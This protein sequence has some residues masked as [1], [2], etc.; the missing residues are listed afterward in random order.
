MQRCTGVNAV[1]NK[2][3]TGK[4][5][6]QDAN[7]ALGVLGTG[8]ESND[9][10]SI[11][12][13]IC[14]VIEATGGVVTPGTYNQLY[15]GI[16]VMI[17]D[18]VGGYALDTGSANTFVVTLTPAIAALQ[19]GMEVR[20]KTANGNPG[21]ASTLN[22]GTGAV[23]LVSD[24]GAALTANQIGTGQLV[25]AVYNQASNAWF[26]TNIMSATGSGTAGHFASWATAATLGD[27]GVIGSAAHMAATS[28][29]VTYVASV[30][31]ATVGH[32]AAFTDANGSI[33][34]S[35][36]VT[37]SIVTQTA[38]QQNAPIVP[39]AVGGT[40]DAITATYSPVP[41][42]L[43]NGMTF[44]VEAASAN[45]TTTPTFTPNSGTIAAATIVKGANQALVAGDIAGARHWVELQWDASLSKWVLLNPAFGVSVRQ[46]AAMGSKIATTSGTAIQFTRLPSGTKRV[47]LS[48]SGV[49][50]STSAALC[51]QLGTGSTPQA[52]GYTGES[53]YISSSGTAN[54]SLASSTSWV[55][56]TQS[57]AGP[58]WGQIT[59]TLVDTATNTWIISG[60][61]ACS[62]SVTFLNPVAYTVALTGAL[63]M[64]NMTTT[65]GSAAF[66]GGM[67]NIIYE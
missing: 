23:A 39:S 50:L 63:G 11:Q 43:T 4:A 14:H 15:T 59:A 62:G 46:G 10:D 42:A 56:M 17:E 12:E 44:L 26:T 20:F 35:G 25:T 29:A 49:T 33:G 28:V 67:A 7:G 1:T 27:G 34:D 58:Y 53:A 55:A 65:G 57:D 54:D 16:Q 18:A 45:A 21:G 5:G 60:L 66:S 40:S 31:S 64:I 24:A 2:F 52:S 61:V 3:G 32:L 8:I 22:V 36:V 47:V 48:I 51:F 38:F 41:T 19:D 9:L 13:E 6:R 37:T 30:T